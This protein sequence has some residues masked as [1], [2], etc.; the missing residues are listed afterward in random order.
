LEKNYEILNLHPLH[1]PAFLNVKILPKKTKDEIANKFQH[2][3]SHLKTLIKELGYSQKE[4]L[5]IQNSAQT[6]LSS[7]LKKMRSEDWSHLIPKFIKYT[8]TLD[9]IR[10]QKLEQALPELYKSLNSS[11]IEI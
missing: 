5:K 6:L 4:S 7:Y 10:E 2:F 1:N 3:L 9:Q 11:G 8:K